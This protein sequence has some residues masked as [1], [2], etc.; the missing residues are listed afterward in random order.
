MA[1]GYTITEIYN[2]LSP[3]DRVNGIVM[4]LIWTSCWGLVAVVYLVVGIVSARRPHT[5]TRRNLVLVAAAIAATAIF[6]QR[7]AGFS[8]GNSISDTLPPFVGVRTGFGALLGLVGQLCLCVVIFGWVA[9][10]RLDR[11]IA[12]A[13]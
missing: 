5:D 10:R 8:L 2:A 12:Q 9:P 6:A 11:Q 4:A 13:A 3:S 1:P 7:F